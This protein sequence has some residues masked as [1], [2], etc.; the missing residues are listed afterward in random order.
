MVVS[1]DYEELFGLL[2]SE[3]AEY[4]VVGGHALAFHGAPRYT[5]DVDIF[6]ST[7]P[8]NAAKVLRAIQKFG[9]SDLPLEASDFIAP[10]RV[11]QFGYPPWRIDILTGLSG[12]RFETAWKSKIRA[13][14]GKI[15]VW[16]ISK[17]DL[18][19]NK[20]S[21]GRTRDLAD[22]EAL[23]IPAKKS[24]GKSGKRR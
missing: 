24:G 9:F 8:R 19:R 15:P 2:N 23:G 12:V 16:F 3:K 13:R 14:Y 6:V 22:L 5:G 4:L 21:A 7:K 18:V 10:N 17:G 1:R 20:R 11:I